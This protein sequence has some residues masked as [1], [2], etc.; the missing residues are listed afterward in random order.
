MAAIGRCMFTRVRCDIR[1][2]L[3]FPFICCATVRQHALHAG[4][5][6]LTCLPSAPAVKPKNA[7]TGDFIAPGFSTRS[8][9]FYYNVHFSMSLYT[10]ICTMIY[11]SIM[12][13]CSQYGRYCKYKID[14]CSTPTH[15]QAHTHTHTHTCTCTLIPSK[16]YSTLIQPCIVMEVFRQ[17]SGIIWVYVNS[18]RYSRSHSNTF[19]QM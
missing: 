9:V 15:A 19:P 13:Q 18:I 17:R 6:L 5:S 1:L 7:L 3:L 2:D 14:Y 11:L 10:I 4:F 8:S 16:A 12:Q